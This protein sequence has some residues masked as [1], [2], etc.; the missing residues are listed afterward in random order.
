[1]TEQS[2]AS[3]WGLSYS[4]VEYLNR[5]GVK[6]RV[7]IACQLLFY[8]H[9]GRFPDDRSEL[10]ADVIAYVA[11]QTAAPDDISYAFSSDTARRPVSKS[12]KPILKDR[13]DAD[14]L[15]C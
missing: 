9:H 4:D 13:D 15:N 14:A 10:D 2:F 8:R 6:S 5:F 7:M 3:L 1:M 11:D 12:G